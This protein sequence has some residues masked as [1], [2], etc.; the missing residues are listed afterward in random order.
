VWLDTDGL[1]EGSAVRL[2]RVGVDQV[3]VRRGSIRLTGGAPALRLSRAPTVAASIPVAVA[4]R[5]EELAPDVERP[6]AEAMWGALAAD[7][8]GMTP[9]ELILDL[10]AVPPGTGRFLSHLTEVAATP[11]VP[12]VS[13]EQLRAGAAGEL[14]G[15][16]REVVVPVYGTEDMD[17]RGIGQRSSLELAERLGPLAAA[18]LRVRVGVVLRPRSDPGAGRWGENLD[19]LCEGDVAEVSTSSHL[20]RTF[21]FRKRTKW[22]GPVWDVDDRLALRWIDAA[23]LHF[24]LSETTRLV[25]PELAGWDLVPL[26][27]PAGSAGL[28]RDG[29]IAYLGGD[30]P[31]PTVDVRVGRYGREISVTMVNRSPFGSAVSQYGNWVEVAVESG[32]LLAQDSGNFDR[33]VLGTRSSGRWQATTGTGIDAVRFVETYLAPGEEMRT[34]TVRLPSSRTRATIRWNVALTTGEDVSGETRG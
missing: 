29:L 20:D 1:D 23:R 32:A 26:P 25:L 33:V 30:G 4:L 34:G 3:V 7:L 8:R 17:L 2:Q 22:G 18:G 9:S 24:F 14:A 6:M 16:V 21:V 13:I 10:P 28:S 15:A 11:V 19:R 27:P 31:A 5:V 12:I